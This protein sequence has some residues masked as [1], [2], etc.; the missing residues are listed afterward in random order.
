M[1]MRTA[2]RRPVA[3]V[4]GWERQG[5]HSQSAVASDDAAE[6]DMKIFS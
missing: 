3:G 1:A 6:A 4:G 2:A 5:H